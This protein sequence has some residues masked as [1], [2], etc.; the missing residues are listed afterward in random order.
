MRNW[1]LLSVTILWGF[2][3]AAFSA[4]ISWSGGGG[5]TNFTTSGNWSGGT[6]P[7]SSDTASFG[8]ATSQVVSVNGNR[9]IGAA[10]F[11]AP[12]AYTFSGSELQINSGLTQTG[13]GT[14][15]FS[16]NI[17][18]GGAQTWNI[19]TGSTTTVTGNL[20]YNNLWNLAFTKA[21]DGLLVLS[22]TNNFLGGLQVTGGTVRL[23][24]NYAMGTTKIYNGLN[25]VSSGATLELNGGISV[26][27]GS[28]VFA[29]NGYSGNGALRSTNGN[30]SLDAQLSLSGNTRFQ[31]DAGS[32]LT[33][34]N[35]NGVTA[36]GYGLT[37]AG[38]G[39]TKMVTFAG[40]LL[41]LT[42]NGNRTFSGAVYNSNYGTVI[43]NNGNTFF[44]GA[45][46]TSA[47]TI[48]GSGSTYVAGTT[49]MGGAVQIT[50][51]GGNNVF[52]GQLTANGVTISGGS[53]N[54]FLGG[55]QS[56]NSA[57][58]I[59]STGNQT[60]SG[61]IKSTS[62]SM[63]NSG[64]VTLIGGGT[65][66][67][68]NMYV[69]GGSTLNLNKSSGEVQSNIIISN[70][71]VRLGA[72]EQIQNSNDVSVSILEGGLLDLN[73]HNDSV[74]K[75]KMTSGLVTTGTGTLTISNTGG[76]SLLT[77]ASSNSSTITGHLAFDG[78]LPMVSV[79][80]GAAA[81]DLNVNATIQISK[82][83]IKSGDGVMKINQAVTD[84]NTAA[85]IEINQGTL[86]L[87]ASNIIG[88]NIQI[89]LSGGTFAT[90]G[91]SEGTA[92]TAGLG[93]LTLSSNSTIDMGSGNSIIDF[94]SA[95]YSSGKL[96]VSNWSGSATGGGTDQIHF[97]TAPSSTF[98]ANVYW[99]DFGT[100]GAKMIGNEMVPISGV[101]I[102]PEPGTVIGGLMVGGWA[103][104]RWCK[105]RDRL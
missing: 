36:N 57:V 52:T 93:K 32:T 30:N 104:W 33:L 90:G 62:F 91:F 61:Q 58:T 82:G 97:I 23:A 17:Q 100:T 54:S 63:T 53:N 29:G 39:D 42:G 85:N 24:S 76:T 84:T 41:T 102:V 48:S 72:N 83:L 67:A 65:I 12:N 98:L 95:T 71:T 55:I 73:N 80:N 16:N 19:G 64:T 56:Q 78:D 51:S 14:V 89:K 88:N 101:P 68:N 11:T 47:L 69:S 74:D 45:L 103:L 79:Q 8:T 9:T 26:A 15:L 59:N 75:I 25:F 49:E 31:T 60:V 5:N 66:N 35:T 4:T 1:F 13:G 6:Y 44:G 2:A 18:L 40:G 86:L 92:T 20:Y 96:T 94:D 99:A 28:I 105:R 21:G 38:D 27:Q 70:A 34:V 50:G 77:Y 43:Q 3:G 37:L 10:L 22:G 81:V 87:G 46:Q 7:G